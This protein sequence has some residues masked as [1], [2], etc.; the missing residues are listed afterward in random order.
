LRGFR[1]V[2]LA[3]MLIGLIG[4]LAAGCSSQQAAA[5]EEEKLPQLT[6]GS[7]I[8]YPPLEYVDPK[9][10][11]NVGFDIDLMNA[12]GKVEG[13]EPVF[14]NMGFDAI[15]AAVKSNSVDLGM[16]AFPI[17]EDCQKEVD[18]SIPYYQTGLVI[19]VK[20]SN[21]DI[22]NFDDLKDKPLVAQIG[23]TGADKSAEISKSVK[24]Y[25]HIPEALLD[26]KNGAAVALVNDRPVSL[27]YVNQYPDEYKVVG[28]VLSSEF[29]GIAVAKNRPEVLQKINDGLNKLKASGEYATIYKKWFNEDPEPFL[30][31]EPP[32]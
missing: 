22:K 12:I 32:K 10:N 17:T 16:S 25:D 19:A 23:T 7:E 5:P 30:P 13:F 8:A 26:I 1:K 15:I 11:S 18:F 3:V 14:K 24:L 2:L 20:K 29:Y 6:V 28:D 27:Y 9:T 4:L 31:G 21:E